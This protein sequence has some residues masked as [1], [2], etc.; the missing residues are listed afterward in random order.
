MGSNFITTAEL[1]RAFRKKLSV[2]LVT[3]SF[4]TYRNTIL[5]GLS[6]Y[7][8]EGM[9]LNEDCT[10][11]PAASEAAL[12]VA[13]LLDAGDADPVDLTMGSQDP[14]TTTD[15]SK[16]ND[17]APQG[18]KWDLTR[19]DLKR[20]RKRPGAPRWTIKLAKAIAEVWGDKKEP[21]PAEKRVWK[22]ILAFDSSGKEHIEGKAKEDKKRVKK[23]EKKKAKKLRKSKKKPKKGK[24][25]TSASSSSDSD[26]S[27]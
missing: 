20:I 4:V 17:D 18:G 25:D 3:S 27:S 8:G 24:G 11:E 16:A 5:F 23:K 19:K 15:T 13:D 12:A 9:A 2:C 1:S 26:S 22:V 10:L 6:T 21:G 7:W 14:G